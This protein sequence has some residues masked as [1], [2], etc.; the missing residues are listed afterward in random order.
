MRVLRESRDSTMSMLEAFVHDPL[1]NWRL[2]HQA[3]PPHHSRSTTPISSSNSESPPPSPKLTRFMDEK[4][5]GNDDLLNVGEKK[6]ILNQKALEVID[7]VEAKLR[8]TDFGQIVLKV[9]D[10]VEKLIEQATSHDNLSQLYVGW[11]PF[12]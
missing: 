12:W 3:S 5:L 10:Q 7:R 4:Q 2:L 1:I 9:E 8:G 6:E 11:C